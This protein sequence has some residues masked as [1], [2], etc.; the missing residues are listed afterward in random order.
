MCWEFHVLFPFVYDDS[1]VSAD[2]DSSGS[3][4]LLLKSRDIDRQLAV[5]VGEYIRCNF[6]VILGVKNEYFGC[7]D[8]ARLHGA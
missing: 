6:E 7:C 8:T 4:C 3:P 1:D 5:Y 2:R